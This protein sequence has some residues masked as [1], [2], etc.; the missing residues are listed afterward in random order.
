M[1][2]S[3]DGDSKMSMEQIIKEKALELGFA[4]VGI[5]TA[6][7]FTEYAQE[8]AGRPETFSWRRDL[9]EKSSLK[10]FDLSTFANPAHA[11]PGVKSLIVVSD[12]YFE[13]NFPPSLEGKIGRCYQAGLYAKEE[14]VYKRRRKDFK[15]F[16]EGLGMKTIFGPAPARMAGARAG[17]TN[18]GKNAFAFANQAAGQSSWI[19]NETF[20]VDQELTPDEPTMKIGCPE[21]CTKCIDACP[22]R[23][24]FAPLKMDSRKCIA[25]HTYFS[26]EEIPADLRTKMGTWVYGCDICQEVCPRNQK[27]LKKEK[28]MNPLLQERAKDFQITTLLTMSQEHYEKKVW[29]LLYYIRQE[30]RKLWQRNAAIALG[31]QGDPDSVPSLITALDDPEPLVRGH[32]AWALGKIGGPKSR[33]ALEKRLTS[34]ADGKV[35]EEIEEA[36]EL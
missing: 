33:A 13:E 22:T 23:A 9:G 19:V 7:P 4:D 21:N 2:T 26:F 3:A 35:R 18:Y 8:L 24:I 17:I 25:R 10:Y 34:E 11:M 30:N 6:D 32:V 1:I 16:L 5:T 12:S 28:P 29:P 15:I 36:L 14:T 27:Q 20:L 31:N